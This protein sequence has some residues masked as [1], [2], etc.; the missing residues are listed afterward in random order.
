MNLIMKKLI[1]VFTLS[2]ML[3]SC[4]ELVD[5]LNVDPNNPTTAPYDL[6]LTG[7]QLGNVVL[8][9]GEA[10][11]KAG[12]FAGQ[13][14]GLDRN[15]LL[16]T[17]YNVAASSFNA[18]WNNVY[19][20]VIVNTR[21]AE[22]LARDSGVEG[23]TT[24]ILQIVRAM[25]F[26]TA[27]S[28]WGDIPF[29]DGGFPEVISPAFEEQTVV[30]GKIQLLL[31]E[32]I[33]NL[34]S[35]TGRPANGADIHFNGDPV[36][37][38][39]VAYAL[40][41]RYYMHTRDYA[42]AFA[43]AQNGI[44]TLEN[45]LFS[46]HGTTVPE[47]NLNYQFLEI[48]VRGADMVTSDFM[49]SLVDPN[50]ANSPDI[51]NYRGNAKTNETARY[52]YLFRTTGVGIQPNSATG[53]ASIDEPGSMITYQ[54]TLLTLAEAGTRSGGFDAGLTA[55]NNFRAFMGSGGYL[56]SPNPA[57][58]LYDAYVSA[59][60]DNGGIANLDGQTADDALLREILE[61]RYITLFG[62]VETFS[63]TRRTDGELTVRVPV[64]ANT[65]SVLP[66]RF[67]Y[68][69]SEIDRN[70]NAPSPIPDFFEPTDVNQ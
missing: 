9:T 17:T 8:Q 59:D 5:D 2:L 66:Q 19:V 39:E 60:F 1:A 11:R 41:A 6:V 20:D 35:G 14:T 65:G 27:A 63:D 49:A 48:A 10:T 70:P 33:N 36:A 42:N 7:A 25:A 51:T 34:A 15:H 43:A 68:P 31:D 38:A 67:V 3:I 16:Y 44:S 47:A 37:W 13:Y 22:D 28:F 56:R 52:N 55:I 23:I 24:G 12:I 30:Y 50:A 64:Q 40:K 32:A 57:D 46:P 45:S 62:T 53:M 4:A 29:D 18:E 69:Q 54:E 61:E 58:I 26:G 21:V